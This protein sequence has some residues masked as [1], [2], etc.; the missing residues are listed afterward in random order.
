MGVETWGRDGGGIVPVG[1]SRAWFPGWVMG[2]VAV[3]GG[4][5]V[6]WSESAGTVAPSVAMVWARGACLAVDRVTLFGRTFLAC[7]FAAICSFTARMF[8]LNLFFAC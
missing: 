5:G 2:V 1:Y 6:G 3:G 4:C 8:D 7:S